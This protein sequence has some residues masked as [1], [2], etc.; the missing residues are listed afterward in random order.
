MA[1]A[2]TPFGILSEDVDA[3]AAA[4]QAVVYTSGIFNINKVLLA[5]GSTVSAPADIAALRAI[6][7]I[8]K[9][10]IAYPAA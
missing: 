4:V 7:L 5:N 10:P 3:S 9:K 2:G 8:V 1:T 6:N